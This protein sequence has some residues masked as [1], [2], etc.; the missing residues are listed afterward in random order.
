MID[1]GREEAQLFD[2]PPQLRHRSDLDAMRITISGHEG[3]GKVSGLFWKA[4][5]VLGSLM[6]SGLGLLGGDLTQPLSVVGVVIAFGL[7]WWWMPT[8][9]D[10]HPE[11][12]PVEI[13]LGVHLTIERW[14][15][16][17]EI[18]WRKVG[19]ATVK[20][21]L[22][23]VLFV[24]I[25]D[26]PDLEIPMQFEPPEHA[27]WVAAAIEHHARERRKA[28]SAADVPRALRQLT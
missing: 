9:D 11:V 16:S 19:R 5:A 18:D 23:P 12:V 8:N 26:A 21:S 6:F 10:R 15:R 24:R 4:L 2:P 3:P 27:A 25:L 14:G 7:V 13:R 28:G 1:R 17:R 22:E 20:G